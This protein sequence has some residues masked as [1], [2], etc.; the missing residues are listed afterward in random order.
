MELC[1]W[2]GWSFCFLSG[3]SLTRVVAQSSREQ[4]AGF[5]VSALCNG[6]KVGRQGHVRNIF[7]LISFDRKPWQ[8]PFI[9]PI[10]YLRILITI[11]DFGT[12]GC[13][14]KQVGGSVEGGCR[15]CVLG[16]PH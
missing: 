2:N 3:L 4:A 16:L 12:G 8:K 1:I 11:L 14:R 6:W 5:P 10:L 7:F 9:S 13:L 15:V